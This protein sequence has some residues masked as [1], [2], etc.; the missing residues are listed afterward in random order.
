MAPKIDSLGFH[1]V[2]IENA[3]AN[4]DLSLLSL[5]KHTKVIMGAVTV[6]RTEVETEEEVVS[7]VREALKFIPAERLILA[8]DCGLGMLPLNIIQQKLQVMVKV[9]KQF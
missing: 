8:P 6:A 5:F 4:N 9:A 1:E 2:S 3:E 7:K